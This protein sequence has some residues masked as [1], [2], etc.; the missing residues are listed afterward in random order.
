MEEIKKLLADEVA[1]EIE[2][3]DQLT[4]GGDEHGKAVKGINDM[5]NSLSKLNEST[6]DDSA[7]TC[8]V[9]ADKSE[10]IRAWVETGVKV[11][12]A[13]S[14][15]AVPLVMAVASMN[16]ERSNIMTSEAGKISLRDCLT[17]KRR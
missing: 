11:F 8:E 4:I 7:E 16:F 3:L 9:K 10:K 13:V 17:F 1:R 15:V 14:A 2:E 5:V 12:G 6:K